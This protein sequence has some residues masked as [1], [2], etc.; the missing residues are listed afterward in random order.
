MQGCVGCLQR[1]SFFP[2]SA[3]LELETLLL[4]LLVMQG[5][6]GGTDTLLNHELIERLPQRLEARTEIGLHSI[7]EA[8]YAVLFGGLAWFSWQGAWVALIGI[9]LLAQV[10]V[11]ASDEYI[12]NRIRTL[13]QNERVLHFFI[14]LNFGFIIALLAPTLTVWAT[15]P[16]TLGWVDHGVLSWALSGLALAAFAWSVRDFL[17]W[18][19]LSRQKGA[20][21]RQEE[22]TA[23]PRAAGK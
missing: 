22:K 3:R 5:V 2:R 17:A 16:T 21:S 11:D 23:V 1:K 6:L 20:R 10:I 12:E 13:P 4:A 19:G 15:G 14:V 9:L 18:R 8:I 7:R